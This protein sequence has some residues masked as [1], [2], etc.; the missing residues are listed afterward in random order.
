MTDL[1]FARISKLFEEVRDSGRLNLTEP[2]TYLVQ[3]ALGAQAV[4]KTK[5][6]AP[7]GSPTQADLDHLGSERVVLKIVSPEIIHKTEAKGIRLVVAELPQ[8]EHACRALLSDVPPTYA[9]Y[10]KQHPHAM[11]EQ[12]KGLDTDQLEEQLTQGIEGILLV[13]CIDQE[14]SGFATELFVGIKLSNEFGPVI[15]AGLGGVEMEALASESKKGA[16][17]AIAPTGLVDGRG[18]LEIFKGTFSYKKL[19]GK[20]RGSEAVLTGETLIACFDAYIKFA[21]YYSPLNKHADFHLTEFEVNPFRPREG[22]LAPLDGVCSFIE[23]TAGLGPIPVEKIDCLVRPESIAV[24][25][26]SGKGMNMGRIILNNITKAGFDAARTYIVRPGDEEIDGVKCYPSVEALPEKVDLFIMAVGADQVPEV[27]EALVDHD[28]ANAVILIPGGLGEKKGSEERAAQIE[29]KIRDA[30]LTG[31]GGPI[32]L[33]GNS[34]GVISHPGGY[35]TMFIP[36]TKLPKSRGEKDRKVAFLSQSGAFM[37][38]NMSRMPWLDPALAISMGNQTDL[39]GGYI[40]GRLKNEPEIEVFAVY[41]ESFQ[42]M[43][44]LRF[45]REVKETIALGKDVIFYKA[46]RSAEGKSAT[47][48][49][50]SRVAGEYSICEAAIRQAGAL[51]AEDFMQFS[52]MLKLCCFLRKAKPQGEQIAVVSNAGYEAVGMADNLRGEGFDLSFAAYTEEGHQKMQTI[53]DENRLNTLV[54]VKNPLD[55]TPMATDK[56]FV[57]LIEALLKDDNVKAVIAAAVPLTPA[58]QTLPEGV[59]KWESIENPES[60]ANLLPALM[61]ATD[62]PLIG[63]VDSGPIFDPLVERMEAQGLPVFRTAD[64]AVRA[65]GEWIRFKS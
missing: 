8:V 25:G 40:L 61:L 53:L 36:E 65:L 35:D 29:K 31:S 7:G 33:G 37:I 52:D 55:I 17:L 30:H 3:Q 9:N 16:A 45:A 14:V 34:L 10:L 60:L 48:G 41:M 11:P 26:V 56:A 19:T 13:E 28:K 54:D 59:V 64:S 4:P 27:V 44:G 6:I 49:H 32:F 24:I 43:D 20:M 2:E 46:G 62:K 18:F 42:D 38:A 23:A 63:V 39:T 1:D 15:T 57:S 51:V 58:M 22:K 5:L 12:C 50:T 47:A 21:N